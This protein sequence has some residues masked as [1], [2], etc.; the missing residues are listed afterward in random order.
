[1]AIYHLSVKIIGRSTGRSSVA[2]ACY[3]SGDTITNQYDGITHDYRRK[4]WI[5]HTEILLPDNAPE[6]FKDRS[7][8]WNS[9]EL[10]EKSGNSQLS[11]EVELALPRELTLE[12]QT[13][14]VRTYIEQNFTSQGMCADV[15]IH[16][17]P[18]TD[19]HGIPLDSAG[20]PTHNP[21][22][23]VFQNPHAH[24][25]L[26]MR[27]L[28]K[29]GQ[30]EPKYQK[31]YLCRKDNIEKSIPVTEIKQA[32]ADGWTKQYR[33]H[34]GKK[35][36]WL[37]SDSAAKKDLKRVDKQPK[38]VNVP[39]PII[40]DWNSKDSLNRWR[41]SWASM[42]NHALKENGINEQIDHRS[43]ESQGINKVASVHLGPSA[44][45]AEK[46]GVRTELG[47]LNREIAE[48]NYFLNQFK[49]QIESMEKAQTERLEKLSSRL[50]GLRAQYI[51][52]AYQQIMLSATLASE[53][54]Q[55][56][57][58]LA[59]AA[60]MAK[61]AEQLLK[62]LET[63][64]QTLAVKQQELET[65]NPIQ[66]KKRKELESEII[67]T[68]KKINAVMNRL[69][70]IKS[71]YKPEMSVPV[72][73]SESVEQKRKRMRTL[74]EIQAQTY[75]E[76]YS[77]VEENKENMAELQALISRKRNTYDIHTE[78]KLKEHF[79]DEFEK[80]ILTKAREQAP[81]L[82]EINNTGIKNTKSHRR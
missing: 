41:E 30:W 19:G 26:T 47:N 77:L 29:D 63:L 57:T 35:K 17:P 2:A 52:S 34:V 16:N 60:A 23:M 75:K 74:K 68:E 46:R 59:V 78:V 5:E 13:V 39:N 40:A 25:M 54:D 67:S 82:S 9:V 33:Y 32:E 24:I 8:L 53:Q 28:D 18:V 31:S 76:F 6:S 38:S 43:Y 20:N 22:Q 49:N 27:P 55:T 66:M 45:Q 37:T 73:T 4:Y 65:L 48:D 81:E 62:V 56:Q 79:A 12:Q 58:Q 14:L 36:I 72:S 71:A 15:A 50:E 3:R 61:G 69:D 80:S 7:T 51:A 70:E 10:A 42:C 21:E 1:M 11:R 44:H 64:E